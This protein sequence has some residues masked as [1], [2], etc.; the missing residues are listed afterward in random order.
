LEYARGGRNI[1]NLRS[2]GYRRIY[3]PSNHDTKSGDRREFDRALGL[4]NN[5]REKRK[6]CGCAI[7]VFKADAIDICRFIISA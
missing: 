4:F 1:R 3:V 2:N 6:I 5:R 7:Y